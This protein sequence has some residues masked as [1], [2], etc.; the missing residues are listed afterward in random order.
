MYLCIY[1]Y[2]IFSVIHS[3]V[4]YIGDLSYLRNWDL[5][6]ILD[7]AVCVLLYTDAPWEGMYLSLP[8]L[9]LK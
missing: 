6:Q 4:F 7:K 9:W 1:S 8:Q 5:V 2:S 3:T